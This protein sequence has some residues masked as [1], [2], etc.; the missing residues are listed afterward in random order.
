M[1]HHFLLILLLICPTFLQAQVQKGTFAITDNFRILYKKNP[2]ESPF[3]ANPQLNVS[4]PTMDYYL[5][6]NW[7][8]GGSASLVSYAT[9]GQGAA[10]RKK[11]IQINPH[12]K[13]GVNWR[14]HN[15][16][17]SASAVY[18]KQTG[19]DNSVEV[20]ELATYLGAGF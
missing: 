17:L 12:L 10:V 7:S 2:Q 5:S 15:L 8:I 1:Q 19:F 13:F 9:I 14:R 6:K 20:K 11:Q 4:L 16:F 3:I 18:L